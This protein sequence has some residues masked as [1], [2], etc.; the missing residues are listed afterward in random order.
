MFSALAKQ[1]G[2]LEY[3]EEAVAES[4]AL[5]SAGTSTSKKEL[6][7]AIRR[8]LECVPFVLYLRQHCVLSVRHT[9]KSERSVRSV[10]APVRS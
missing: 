4:R 3:A 10:S 5:R 8:E 9:L 2:L 6:F 1:A 7:E